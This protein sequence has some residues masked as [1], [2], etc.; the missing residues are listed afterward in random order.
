MP[1]SISRMKTAVIAIVA[2][3]T[4]ASAP[5]FAA[6]KDLPAVKKEITKR[7][8]EA[9]KRLQDWIALPSIA[10][11]NLNYP[12]GAEHMAKLARDAGFQQV[13]RDRHRRQARRV[14][15]ARRRRAEDGR[16]LLHVRREAVRSRRVDLAAARGAHRRQ[17]RPRQGDGRP[18]RGEPEGARGGVP[19]GAAR[20]PRRRAEAAGEPRAGRRGR[21]GDRLAAHRP[22]RPPARGARRRCASASASSCR[23]RRRTSTASSR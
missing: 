9:V 17:A 10:A 2:I 6:D 4:A 15:H 16:P 18:R 21:G 7:H 13:D 11:E 1:D 23:R 20:H 22:D 5:S 19:R 14:R 3:A 8:D 12:E